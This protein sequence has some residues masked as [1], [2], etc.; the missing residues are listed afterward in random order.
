M[1]T[2]PAQYADVF[3]KAVYDVTMAR[4]RIYGY[5]ND[6]DYDYSNESQAMSLREI[7]NLYGTKEAAQTEADK[8]KKIV[9]SGVSFSYGINKWFIY[10]NN[11]TFLK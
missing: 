7:R 1:I 8:G 3:V 4:C 11:I 10:N 2:D 5:E 9:V 6:P